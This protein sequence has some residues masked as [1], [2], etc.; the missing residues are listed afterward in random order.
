MTRRIA[1]F[2]A[3]LALSLAANCWAMGAGQSRQPADPLPHGQENWEPPEKQ[4]ESQYPQAEGIEGN[5]QQQKREQRPYGGAGGVQEDVTKPRDGEDDRQEQRE[6]TD[7]Q[8]RQDREG[9]QNQA[10]NGT[11][12]GQ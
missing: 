2:S 12:S 3:L 9:Q 4:F 10:G 6:Q 11:A 8:D 1:L 5:P 7:R